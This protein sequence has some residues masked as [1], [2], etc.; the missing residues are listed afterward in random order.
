MPT[1]ATNYDQYEVMVQKLFDELMELCEH[2][3]KSEQDV[4]KIRQAFYFAKNAHKGV[5]R[6]SGEPYIT[7]PLSVAK[8]VVGEIGLGS[9]S[10]IAALLHDV[11]ED[12]DYTVDDIRDLFGEKIASMVDGLTKLSGVFDTEIS[13]QA[14]NFKKMLM[15]LSD[16]IR[17][18]IIKIADRLHNMRTLGSMPQH[19]QMKIA[20]ETIYLFA[21]LANRL[22]LYS[23]KSE[24]E[25]LSLKYRFPDEYNEI[26]ENLN[27]TEAQRALFIERFIEPIKQ[28]LTESEIEFQISGR[29]KSVYS[30][31]KKMKSKQLSFNEIYDLCAFRIIF[32]P[33]KMIPEKTQ[34][35]HIYSL[36]TDIYKSHH[37]R[38]RDWVTTPKANGYEALHCTVMSQ[39]GVWVEVQI[40]SKRMH[41][42]AEHGLAAHWKYKSPDD[43][44]GSQTFDLELDNSLKDLRE[45]LNNPEKDPVEFLDTF[46]MNLAVSEIVVFTPKGESKVLPKNA[47]VLDFAYEIHS[48]IGNTALG[49]KVNYKLVPL[50]TVIH[51]GDQIEIITSD[52]VSPSIDWLD[53]VTTAKAKSYIKNYLKRET[54]DNIKKGQA[55]FEEKL[56]QLGITMHGRVLHKVVPA[57]ECTNKDQFYS[58]LGLG[59]I[60]IDSIEKILKQNA[61]SKLVKY[62][63]LQIAKPFRPKPSKRGEQ[64]NT[65]TQEQE[66]ITAD[67]Q[68]AACCSP[69]PGDTIIGFKKEGGNMVEVHKKSCPEAVKL[70]S[71]HGDRI[72]EAKWSS[73]SIQSHLEIIELRGIDRMGVLLD[74]AKVVSGEMGVN[75]R[76][77]DFHSHDGI[78]SGKISFYVQN[79]DDIKN[80]IHKVGQ[81]KGVEKITRVESNQNQ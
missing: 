14:E 27:Q 75:I 4:E 49:A 76:A 60:N 77:V 46:K 42:I 31:W 58:R 72:V 25:N 28:K 19:K 13:E 33:T 51:S 66:K 6:K 48:K 54:E 1:P 67:F 80:L 68:V 15:T 12:T 59:I 74:L 53:F 73:V 18:I 55:I 71:Q 11:V 39:D 5:K 16:D 36:I 37:E 9:K 7:H 21:P 65:Y 17:V 40:R 70:S 30:I 64:T 45:A 47:T 78:F 57:Y 52:S 10:V 38:I 35:W 43:K 24:L 3:C 8:I 41:D 32:E 2:T 44:N 26:S 61:A 56:K 22:G 79:R 20:G 34:C 23:I 63:T 69:I 62:W 29:V 50:S 81:I